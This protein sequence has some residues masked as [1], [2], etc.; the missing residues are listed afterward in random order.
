MRT[1]GSELWLVDLDL[2]APV[3]RELESDLKLLGPADIARAQ[4][5]NDPRERRRRIA[6]Y[7]ALR[8]VLDRVLGSGIRGRDFVRT[9]SGKPRWER[10]QVDFSL[11]H[12]GGLALIGLD[13]RHPIGVDLE[14]PRAAK[15]PQSAREK[16]M[17]AAR[18][19]ARKPVPGSNPGD[20]DPAFVQAWSRLEAFAKVRGDGLART[21]AAL[22]VRGTRGRQKPVPAEIESIARQNARQAGVRVHDLSLPRGYCGAIA[23]AGPPPRVRPLPTGRDTLHRLLRR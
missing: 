14:A 15:P 22:G 1:G 12:S 21:L 19:L 16:I 5:L 13:R 9:P 20:G 8:I 2:A 3:L 18:G 6:A 10:T 4:R 7:T 23:C 11:A 17:A